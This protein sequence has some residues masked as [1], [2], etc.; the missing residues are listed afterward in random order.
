LINL[1][2]YA[3]MLI[4]VVPTSSG[5]SYSLWFYWR[6]KKPAAC[7]LERYDTELS[8]FDFKTYDAAC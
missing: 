2:E 6:H 4:M 7:L 1:N 3:P 8:P 5:K